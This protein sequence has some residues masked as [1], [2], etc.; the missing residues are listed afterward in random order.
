MRKILARTAALAGMVIAG[1][2]GAQ[3]FSVLPSGD[4]VFTTPYTFSG[5]F[6]CGNYAY[7]AGASCANTSSGVHLTSGAATLDLSFEGASGTFTSSPAGPLP[8][9]VGTVDVVEGGT[10]AFLYP[11]AVTGYSQ[12]FFQLPISLSGAG[13]VAY[14]FYSSGPTSSITAG[15]GAYIVQPIPPGDQVPGYNYPA[16]VYTGPGAI[17]IGPGSATFPLT[18]QVGLVPEPSSLALL[19]TGLLGLAPA[20]RRRLT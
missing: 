16:L 9:I 7:F 18:A 8:L 17:T 6:V 1:S 3:T 5:T 4:V 11:T 14:H 20:I 13:A 2:A 15:G 10:G 12:W 19:G